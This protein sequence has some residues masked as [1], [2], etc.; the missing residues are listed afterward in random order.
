MRNQ[1]NVHTRITLSSALEDI[2]KPCFIPAICTVSRPPPEALPK[3]S[4]CTN[5]SV[6][7]QRDLAFPEHFLLP[8]N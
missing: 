6:S 5:A 4:P 8:V 7:C 3:T 2:H 1:K